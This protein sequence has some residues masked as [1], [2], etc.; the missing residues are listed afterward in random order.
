[1]NLVSSRHII[2]NLSSGSRV[3]PCGQTHMPKVMDALHNFANASKNH[4]SR[5]T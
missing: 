1:M 2:E 5:W 4:I 3:I